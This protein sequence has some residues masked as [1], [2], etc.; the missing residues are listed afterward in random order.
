[1]NTPDPIAERLTREF[2]DVLPSSLIESTVSTAWHAVPDHDETAV[3]MT[4]R[5]D[6]SAL[7]DAVIRSSSTGP[8]TA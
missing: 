6:I 5:A 2:G 3:T 4:A 7:A 8:L 1:M